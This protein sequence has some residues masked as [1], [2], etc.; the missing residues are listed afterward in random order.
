LSRRRRKIG[1]CL[2]AFWL[3]TWSFLTLSGSENDSFQ[4]KIP[5]GLDEFSP[6]IPRGNPITREKI[7]LGRIL[8]FDKR[9]SVDGSIA[10]AS[11][12]DPK[13]AFT[14]GKAVP[15][16]IRGQKGGRNTPTIINRLFSSTQFWDGRVTG[17]EDQ[18][19]APFVSPHEMGN[20]SG[21]DLIRRLKPVKGYRELFKRAF[22]T[23]DFTI[24]QVAKA[25]ASFERIVL[26]GNSPFDQFE[27]GGKEK[28]LAES[29][30]RGLTLFRG[31]ARCHL[32]HTG[33]NLTD[34]L[35]HN[36]GVGW[37]ASGNFRDLGRYSVTKR[38]EDQGKFKTPT[39]R[40]ITKTAPYMH[41]G[42]LPTLEDVIDFYDK[43]GNKNPNLDLEMRPLNLTTQEK[44]NLIEFLKALNGE[45]W[46]SITPPAKFPE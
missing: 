19:K 2:A 17:L 39:L 31:K 1:I 16:G 45:G 15:E 11:C 43:G 9:L 10:C 14:D 26:S 37:E 41:D 28:A 35:F 24:D 21:D 22:G 13:L 23:E 7:E 46:Q 36:L 25:I 8:F 18:A 29:A 6:E 42:S 38:E 34:E 5:L 4:F 32:C 27:S 12:H 44:K 30:R 3:L 40:E 20:P 33:F